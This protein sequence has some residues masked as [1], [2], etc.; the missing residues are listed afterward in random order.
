MGDR[1]TVVSSVASVS[2]Y[3]NHFTGGVGMEHTV[4]TLLFPPPLFPGRQIKKL[5]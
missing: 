5:S 3:R 4:M 1:S 2:V